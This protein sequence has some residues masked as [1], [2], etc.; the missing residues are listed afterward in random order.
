MRVICIRIK[1]IYI[2]IEECVAVSGNDSHSLVLANTSVKESLIP[3][4]VDDA[5]LG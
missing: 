1:Y 3:F 2:K 5:E 4:V